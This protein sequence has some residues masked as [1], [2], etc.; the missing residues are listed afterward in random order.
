MNEQLR[1]CSA[2]G[3]TRTLCV[4]NV[5]LQLLHF[6]CFIFHY[7]LLKQRR[8]SG[9]ASRL[10]FTLKEGSCFWSTMEAQS[11]LA[12]TPKPVSPL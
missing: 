9:V 11:Q 3:K 5:E 4:A 8:V 12:A 7:W 10:T 1:F 2:S 6:L